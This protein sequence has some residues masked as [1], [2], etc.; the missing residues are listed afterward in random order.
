MNELQNYKIIFTEDQI[1]LRIKELAGQI[2]LDYAG[3]TLDVVC[4]INSALFFCTKLVSQLTIPT[5]IH[6][7]GFTSYP[8][9]NVTGEV[10]ITLDIP[11]PLFDRHILIIEGIVVTGRTPR[12]ITE[13][14]SLR[15]PASISLCALGV[16][17]SLLTEN[18]PLKYAAFELD[19]HVAAGFGV[20]SG[21]EKT[22]QFLY[23]SI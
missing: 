8:N 13:M 23:D 7:L 1:N 21:S 10:R 18:L 11:E 9:G 5:R 17:T 20:G 6:S 12:Y 22:L 3:K 2:S 4:L 19:N 14:L 16:K 15:K